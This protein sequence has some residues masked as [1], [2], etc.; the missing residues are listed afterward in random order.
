MYIYIYIYIYITIAGIYI[1]I[2]MERHLAHHVRC[3]LYSLHFLLPL[4]FACLKRLLA[5]TLA[6]ERLCE[7]RYCS[8][9]PPHLVTTTSIVSNIPYDLVGMVLAHTLTPPLHPDSI[10]QPWIGLDKASLM[11]DRIRMQWWDDLSSHTWPTG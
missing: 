3:C 1:Y 4:A 8:S 7:T 6:P 10:W 9:S 11:P 5:Q 2:V